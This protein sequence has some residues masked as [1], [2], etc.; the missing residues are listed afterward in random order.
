M[1]LCRQTGTGKKSPRSTS[2]VERGQLVYILSR[3]V[4][5]PERLGEPKQRRLHDPV[6]EH[7]LVQRHVHTSHLF[8]SVPVLPRVFF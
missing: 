4:I 6:D 1:L 3:Y 2:L 7:S 8:H 5:H